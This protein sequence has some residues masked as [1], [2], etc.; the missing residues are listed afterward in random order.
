MRMLALIVLVGCDAGERKPTPTPP[1]P[2]PTPTPTLPADAAVAT[3]DASTIPTPADRNLRID[4]RVKAERPEA[5]CERSTVTVRLVDK[6]KTVV[7]EWQETSTCQ[8]ACTAADKREGEAQVRA[9]ERAID[10]GDSTSSELDYNFTS[11]LETG[12][13]EYR[14]FRNIRGRDVVIFTDRYLGPHDGQYHRLRAIFEVCGQL[15]VSNTFAE[16][17]AYSW[18]IDE[19]RPK[20]DGDG[21]LLVIG[22]H[23]DKTGTLLRV[24]LPPCP[25]IPNQQSFDPHP[26]YDL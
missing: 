16:H 4:V 17:M 13:G 24:E 22:E 23:E 20:A 7:Q 21:V 11:C 8:G 9:T 25:G 14:K 3:I 5:E 12:Y 26:F 6:S 1:P 18:D 10:K 2:T 19:V 15:F